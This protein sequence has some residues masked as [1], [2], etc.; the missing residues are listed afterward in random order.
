[1]K[2][3]LPDDK[4]LLLIYFFVYNLSRHCFS[5]L[6]YDVI[7]IMNEY[8][9]ANRVINNPGTLTHSL[10]ANA[11]PPSKIFDMQK[12][13]LRPQYYT[14]GAMNDRERYFTLH[15]TF[16]ILVFSN[17]RANNIVNG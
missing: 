16:M 9:D 5:G 17:R 8:C 2:N 11:K 6:I 12:I 4:N 3:L 10:S 7:K 15:T 13:E 14:Y 1:M